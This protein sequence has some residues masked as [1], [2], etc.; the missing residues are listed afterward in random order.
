[1]T[2]NP[3]PPE[4]REIVAGLTEAQRRAILTLGESPK[5]SLSGQQIFVDYQRAGIKQRRT[6]MKLTNSGITEPYTRGPVTI[7]SMIRLT[8]LGHAVRSA[9]IQETRNGE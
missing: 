7:Y 3:T 2:T 4:V 9:L 5:A 1:M 8:D 6:R